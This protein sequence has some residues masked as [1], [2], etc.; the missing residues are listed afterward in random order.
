MHKHWPLGGSSNHMAQGQLNV[1]RYSSLLSNQ[2]LLFLLAMWVNY[3]T[4]WI[5]VSYK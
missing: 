3:E 4:V 2:I 1:T 5:E